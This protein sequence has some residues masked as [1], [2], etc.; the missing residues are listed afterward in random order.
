M[1]KEAI[2]PSSGPYHT[3]QLYNSHPLWFKIITPTIHTDIGEG[4]NTTDKKGAS[5]SGRMTNKASP[6]HE[7]TSKT[8][9]KAQQTLVHA[10]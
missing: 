7:P 2:F 3:Q 9:L 8:S 6:I 4:P 10:M 1:D 5:T